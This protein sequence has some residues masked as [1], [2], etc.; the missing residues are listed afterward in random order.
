MADGR[1]MLVRLVVW[2]TLAM[3]PSAVRGYR[4]LLRPMG[5]MR[6]ASHRT[7][8]GITTAVQQQLQQSGSQSEDR[9]QYQV[10]GPSPGGLE[11]GSGQGLIFMTPE[12]W[13]PL[14]KAHRQRIT[15]L[16]GGSLSAHDHRH[17]I[18]NFLFSYYF[19]SPAQIAKWSPGLGVVLLDVQPADINGSPDVSTARGEQQDG[20]SQPSKKKKKKKKTPFKS[21]QGGE[22]QGQA[23]LQGKGF[24]SQRTPSVHDGSGGMVFGTEKCNLGTLIGLRNQLDILECTQAR[25]PVLNCFGFHEWAMLY[26]PEGS[27]APNR[28]QTLPLRLSQGHINRVVEDRSPLKCTHFDAFRFFAPEAQPLNAL[29]LSRSLQ[30]D[31]EQP[32]CVHATMDL[33][34]AAMKLS[35]WIPSE[36]VA[37]C[38]ALARDARVLDMRASPYDL[39]DFHLTRAGQEPVGS[40]P[41][42][43]AAKRHV[44]GTEGGKERRTGREESS[45]QG[46][47]LE[48][49]D[50]A[51][52]FD[53][54]PIRVEESPGRQLYQAE[55]EALWRRAQP[56]RAHVI[57]AYR[58]FLAHVGDQPQAQ[59]DDSH[60]A[61]AKAETMP[62]SQTQT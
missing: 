24:G 1:S 25:S 10:P 2:W 47:F 51:H 27:P 49:G 17:P 62:Q 22:W 23:L 7:R 57:D 18:F 56:L 60:M 52:C 41:R 43:K 20:D 21:G 9:G 30:M 39:S 36:L 33:F 12:E 19:W 13:R 44:T 3:L 48:V 40:S 38:F 54:S 4:V 29:P 53:L 31:H 16:A 6:I 15:D 8:R 11:R 14:A 50:G 58:A 42:F 35:P 34:K 5:V 45:C 46:E 32:G 55:Q 37:D 59:V 61:A 28:H 26:R